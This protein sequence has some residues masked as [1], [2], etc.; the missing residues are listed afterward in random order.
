VNHSL[1]TAH[2][3]DDVREGLRELAERARNA[4]VIAAM[5]TLYVLGNRWGLRSDVRA[6]RQ[7]A[8]ADRSSPHTEEAPAPVPRPPAGPMN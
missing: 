2:S 7:R 5:S 8:R 6:R 3:L 4:I 1:R